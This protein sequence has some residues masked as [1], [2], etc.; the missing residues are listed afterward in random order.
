M[1]LKRLSIK[2]V[3]VI[4]VSVVLLILSWLVHG[5]VLHAVAE[6]KITIDDGGESP[7]TQPVSWPFYARC[8]VEYRS[9]DM[10]KHSVIAQNA[11]KVVVDLLNTFSDDTVWSPQDIENLSVKSEKGKMVALK[12]IATGHVFLKLRPP[13]TKDG[14]NKRDNKEEKAGK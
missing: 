4:V 9:A 7:Q 5:P 1:E 2:W 3:S 14:P 8:E 6:Y 13:A 12:E 11:A 10:A